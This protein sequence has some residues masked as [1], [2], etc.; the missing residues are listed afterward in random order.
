MVLIDFSILFVEFFTLLEKHEKES[1]LAC[2][3]ACLH[4]QASKQASKFGV[5]VV[6]GW[7]CFKGIF[8]LS[9]L[10]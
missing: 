1:L 9:T 3:L 6:V 2:L 7:S 10:E 4:R 5:E 8:L